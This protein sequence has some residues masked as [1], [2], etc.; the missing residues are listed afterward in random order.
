M[1]TVIEKSRDLSPDTIRMGIYVYNFVRLLDLFFSWVF[2]NLKNILNN[3]RF[4]FS[5]YM[6]TK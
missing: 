1:Q 5:Q 2:P 3:L 6:Y 4:I